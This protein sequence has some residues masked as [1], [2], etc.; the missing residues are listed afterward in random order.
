M[1]TLVTRITLL[2]RAP[3][4]AGLH[5]MQNSGSPGGGVDRLPD[6]LVYVND[7]FHGI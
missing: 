2:G 3:D 7:Q 1:T 6:A 4:L 5:S